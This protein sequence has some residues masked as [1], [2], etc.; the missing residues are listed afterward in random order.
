MSE[1]SGI[2]IGVDLGGSNVRAGALTPGGEMISWRETPIQ[3]A[4]GPQ[5]GVQ[6]ISDLITSVVADSQQP[7]LGIGVGS[8]GPLDRERGRIQNPYTLPGWEDVDIVNQLRESFHVPVAFENDADAAAL[9]EAWQ[10]AGRGALAEGLPRLVMVTIGTGVGTGIV[11][12]GKI[13]RGV[14][15]M[16]PEGGH[17]ILDPTGPACYCGAH[18]CWESLVAGPAIA[19]FARQAGGIESSQ[20]CALCA[21]HPE[22]IEAAQVF[23][24]ARQGDAL[25]RRIVDRTADYIAL[26]LVNLIMLYLPDIIVLTGG[27]MRSYDLMEAHIREVIARH[28]VVVPARQVQIQMAQLGQQAGMYGAARAAQLLATASDA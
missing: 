14:G 13:Y 9:G 11:L 4:L 7:L 10:G 27:V 26:G 1:S 19:A 12:D 25:A 23:E 6:R 24:A 20:L 28:D 16:H 17:F 2:L 22:Q 5:A 18:G 8:T 3:A 21:G 15:G